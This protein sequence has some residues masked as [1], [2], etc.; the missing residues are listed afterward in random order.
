MSKKAITKTFNVRK[1]QVYKMLKR[2]LKTE[3]EWLNVN[4]PMKGNL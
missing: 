2:Q 1:T 4:S 3:E